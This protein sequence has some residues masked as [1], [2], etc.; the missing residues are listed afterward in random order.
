MISDNE[1]IDIVMPWVD[2]SDPE[3]LKEKRIYKPDT[4]EDG[5]RFR[6]WEVL[7]YWFRGIE[8]YADWV[9]KVHFITW[10]HIPSWLN[11]DNPKLNIVNHKDYIPAEYLPTFSSHTIEL[12][13]HRID[14]LA[15]RFVYFNDD[16]F[17]CS[18]TSKEDFFKNGLP[19]DMAVL[20]PNHVNG[21]DNQFDHILLNNAEYFARHFNIKEVIKKDRSKWLNL[22]YGK[23]L[24]KT[25]VLM[26]F[27]DFPGIMMHHQPVSFNKSTLERVWEKDGELLDATCRHRFRE[28]TDINQFVFR[29]DQLGRGE[30]SPYNVFKR[31]DYLTIGNG[32]DYSKV[33]NSGYKI[34]C[35]NDT[36]TTVDFDTEKKRLIAAFEAKFKEKS[37]FEI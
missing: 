23:S 8:K 29:Y 35:L 3:W 18:K 21:T 16:I 30:F 4:S 6:D 9:N 32:V 19:C 37:S 27:P 24:I 2:G 11:T 17:L 13:M 36:D 28:A 10:G 1:K 14:G 7:K 33:L 5:V 15:D 22:K 25:M 34:I 12:N 26:L 20:F 31:G